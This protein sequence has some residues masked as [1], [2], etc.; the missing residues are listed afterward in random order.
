MDDQ[1]RA[2]LQTRLLLH[3]CGIF[4]KEWYRRE[5]GLLPWYQIFQILKRLE[6]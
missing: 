3:R 5:R 2:E 6:W 4:V 1:K